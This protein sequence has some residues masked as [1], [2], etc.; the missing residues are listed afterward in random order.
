MMM[1]VNKVLNYCVPKNKRIT[2]FLASWMREFQG[3][4][5]LLSF[6]VDN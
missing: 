5:Q 2:N 4:L 3:R 1:F 6:L